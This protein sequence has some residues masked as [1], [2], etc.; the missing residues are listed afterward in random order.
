MKKLIPKC[1]QPADALRVA[2]IT[3]NRVE[4]MDAVNSFIHSKQ[5]AKRK[6]ALASS[7]ARRFGELTTLKGKPTENCLDTYLSN[8]NK[9]HVT[10]N[11]SFVRDLEGQ[12]FKEIPIEEIQPGDLAMDYEVRGI[13]PLLHGEGLL[14]PSHAM[15][16]N[17]LN[18]EG[19]PTY[20][21]GRGDTEEDW[22]TTNNYR[23]GS[24]YFFDEA[25][26]PQEAIKLRNS[27]L[28]AFRYVGEPEER[29]E[30]IK[31]FYSK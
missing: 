28:K 24:I 8:Y 7:R 22:N 23:K 30:W 17:G 20:N 10:G 25:K 31:E 5:K 19:Y 1:Q 18:S 27:R 21:Y 26:T 2:P 12:G 29:E 15:M 14:S 16:Y 13:S 11:R 3:S 9:D 4:S 6:K